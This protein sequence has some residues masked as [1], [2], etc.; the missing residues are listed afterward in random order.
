MDAENEWERQLRLALNADSKRPRRMS[1]LPKVEIM[2]SF[3]PSK[4]VEID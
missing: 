2:N 3:D 4:N 1:K